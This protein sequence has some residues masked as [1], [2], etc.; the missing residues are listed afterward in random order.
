MRRLLRENPIL[1]SILLN[2]A[3]GAGLGI[4]FVT[5]ILALDLHGIGR[6]VFS[7]SDTAPALALLFGGFIITCAS[8]VAGS[9]IM[10]IGAPEPTPPRA[11]ATAPASLLAAAPVRARRAR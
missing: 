10:R 5:A 4:A 8:V 3:L 2:L 9:A 7:G 1:R 11:G 6:L